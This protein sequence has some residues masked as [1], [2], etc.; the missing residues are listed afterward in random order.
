[1]AT[2]FTQAIAGAR[3]IFKVNGTPVLYA[4]AM[5]Y[6]IQ[7]THQPL[8]VLDQLV[9][10]EYMETAYMVNFSCSM[11]RVPHRDSVSLGL[12]PKLSDILI[13]PGLTVELIDSATNTT[14]V[15]VEQVK[16][17]QET[18]SIDARSLGQLTLDFVGLKLSTE[19][20]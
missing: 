13:Q 2:V 8:E 10:A 3:V 11:F 5:N 17:V 19:G 18:F 20:D 15:L 9:P 4:N 1:M 6:T 14:L 16:C 7:H 12:R